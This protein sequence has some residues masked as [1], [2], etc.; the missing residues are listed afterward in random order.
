[1]VFV[2][3][4][5]L[6]LILLLN[7]MSVQ[8]QIARW[9]VRPDYDNIEM[10]DKGFLKVTEKGRIGLLDKA[11]EE[12][13]PV[14]YDRITP[15]YEDKALLFKD[16]KFCAIIDAYGNLT[17]MSD[18]DYAVDQNNERF[19]SGYLLVSHDKSFYYIDGT[20]RK[21]RGPY[22][23]AFPYSEGYA[24]VK[25]CPNPLKEPTVTYCDLIDENGSSVFASVEERNAVQ[26]VSS[27]MD[28]RALHVSKGRFNWFYLENHEFIPISVDGT[29]NKK[30][31]V[32]AIDKVPVVSPAPNYYQ[33]TAKNAVFRFDKGMK[34][35]RVE[36][37]NNEPQVF[38]REPEQERFFT[39]PFDSVVFNG[40]Y[41]L[42]YKGISILPPQFDEIL[43][44]EDDLA[45]IKNGGRCG[46]I[47]ID[48]KNSF[49]LKLNDNQNVDFTHSHYDAGL[50]VLMPPYIRCASAKV[51]S[52]S[53]DCDIQV[54]TR[55]E[56]ENVERNSLGYTCRLSIPEGLDSDTPIS[57]DYNFIIEYD[58]LR[59]EVHSVQVNEWYVK[60][61][62]VNL[63]N[64]KFEITSPNDTMTVYFELVRMDAAR[65]DDRNYYKNVKVLPADEDPID[66]IKITE[67]HYSFPLSSLGKDRLSF[68]IVIAEE[69]CPPIIYPF[70]VVF[71]KPKPEETD[72]KTTV[73]I[74]AVRKKPA[75]KPAPK[76]VPKKEEELIIYDYNIK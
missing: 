47:T 60:Y 5:L 53:P 7:V 55:I 51:V 37:E 26:F 29:Q 30:S 63:S 25:V 35:K 14:E 11:G 62:E 24:S 40:T 45:V 21:V 67:N 50:M 75:S 32:T 58:G 13:L 66:P 12:V 76:P 44:L 15:F 3:K 52:L 1:M 19:H 46:V 20:G 39:S 42:T 23:E 28:G 33:V 34:I 61:Y 27:V 57:H 54:E 59:S 69:D 18:K 48:K 70:D 10:T 43:H 65:N 68:S 71:T 38:V 6:V 72:Q 73:D 49:Q 41:G 64:T 4:H 22:V 8:A 36:L 56:S 17:D 16:G 31:L 9:M 74:K 2:K